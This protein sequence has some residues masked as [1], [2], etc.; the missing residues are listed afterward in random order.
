MPMDPVTAVAAAGSVL[1]I[2]K[3]VISDV[4]DIID[5]VRSKALGEEEGRKLLTAARSRL[6]IADQ[7]LDSVLAENDKYIDSLPPLPEPKPAPV[8]PTPP[9]VAPQ[10]AAPAAAPSPEP[11]GVE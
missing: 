10:P 6:R 4:I 9:V 3:G 2:G 5:K 11:S 8:Q 1:E 7:T